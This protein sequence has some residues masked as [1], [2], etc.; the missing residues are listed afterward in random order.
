[1]NP[2]GAPQ[3]DSAEQWVQLGLLGN[4]IAQ[5]WYV[6]AH[7]GSTLPAPA[8]GGYISAPGVQLGFNT[9]LLIVGLIALAAVVI[10]SK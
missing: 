6:L 1:M 5:Q 10:I 8:P 2:N 7:P 3:V 9:N 4:N